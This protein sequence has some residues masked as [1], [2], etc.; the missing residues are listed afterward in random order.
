MQ[1]TAEMVAANLKTGIIETLED[2]KAVNINSLDVA[3]ITS[4]T[5][6]MVIVTGNSSTHIRAIAEKVVETAKKLN[7][8]PLGVEG[9]QD[10]EWV[11]ID[12]GGMVIHIMLS[13][14]RDY[15]KLDKLWEPMPI[16]EKAI[17]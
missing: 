6:Y 1:K 2:I 8:K 4:I 15:Y 9:T 7:N 13:H 12:L 14:I 17:A 11:L 3:S 16:E 10:A 5:E